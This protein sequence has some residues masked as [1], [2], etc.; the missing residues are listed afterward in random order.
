[1]WFKGLDL[2]MSAYVLFG[3]VHNLSTWFGKK[4]CALGVPQFTEFLLA[5]LVACMGCLP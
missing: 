2:V 5:E 4:R 3:P 1:M